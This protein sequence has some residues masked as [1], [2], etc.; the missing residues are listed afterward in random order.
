MRR[1][2]LKSQ[3]STHIRSRHRLRASSGERH[4]RHGCGL[5]GQRLPPLALHIHV[6]PI[7][8]PDLRRCFARLSPMQR[9]G[10]ADLAQREDLGAMLPEVELPEP[11]A[12]RAEPPSS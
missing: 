7:L 8:L 12:A 4:G 3:W 10:S 6:T 1:L 2:E 5:D 9:R 11:A